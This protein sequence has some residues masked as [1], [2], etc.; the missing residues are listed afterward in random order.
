M[1]KAE[2]IKVVEELLQEN[3]PEEVASGF[4][5]MFIA[6]KIEFEDLEFLVGLCGYELS[7]EF[8][9]ATPEERKTMYEGKR[10]GAR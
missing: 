2:A 7:D 6:D 5:R 8:K 9:N 4:Y 1:T 10:K 3:T